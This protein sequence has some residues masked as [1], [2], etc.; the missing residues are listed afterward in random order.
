MTIRLHHCFVLTAPKA[1]QA[2]LLLDLGLNEGSSNIHPGQGTANRRFFFSNTMIEFLYVRDANEASNGRGS[3]L[4]LLDRSTEAKASPFGLV[5]STAGECEE[6][7]FPGWRYCPD[8]LPNGQCFHVGENSSLLE[9]PLCICMPPGFHWVETR[10]QSGNLLMTLTELRV[11]V[12]V[13][14]PSQT[15]RAL[16]DCECVSLCLNEPHRLELIFNEGEKGQFKDMN[17]QLPIIVRW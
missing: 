9:E 12:P 14:H 4:Q 10:P 15:L 17:P 1:P 5:V 7:P 11:S 8:Y 16:S 3:R 13:T 2:D 6:E